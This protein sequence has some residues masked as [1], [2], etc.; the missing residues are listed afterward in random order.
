MVSGNG[1]P[2]AHLRCAGFQTRRRILSA[3]GKTES[4]C[5]WT[6]GVLQS[7]HCLNEEI[8]PAVIAAVI[9]WICRDEPV[10]PGELA[11]DAGAVLVFL[12][13]TQDIRDVETALLSPPFA[14]DLR[15][16]ILVLPLHGQLSTED[17]SRVFEI[18]PPGLR[19]IVLATN[20]AESSVTIPDVVYVI[21]SG[22]LKERRFD[23]R[24]KV[25]SLQTHWAS[26]ANNKQRRGRAGRVR[27]GMCVHLFLK[28]RARILKPF[29]TPEMRRVPLEELCLT[30]KLLNLGRVAPVLAEALEPP[31]AA[32]IRIALDALHGIG[33]LDRSERLTALGRSLAQLPLEPRAGKMLVLAAALGVLGPALTIAACATTRDPFFRPLDKRDQVDAIKIQLGGRDSYSDAMVLANT[34]SQWVNSGRSRQWCDDH[35]VSMNTMSTIAKARDQLLDTLQKCGIG[36]RAAN[37]SVD[38]GESRRLVMLR[39]AITGAMWPN[40]ALVAGTEPTM[41]KDG[42]RGQR[43]LLH[44]RDNCG[45]HAHPVSVSPVH[46]RVYA[47]SKRN[48]P[49]VCC[50]TQP[51]GSSVASLSPPSCLSIA[52]YNTKMMTSDLYVDGVTLISSVTAVSPCRLVPYFLP[53]SGGPTASPSARS[54]N[55]IK[56]GRNHSVRWGSPAQVLFGVGAKI[57]SPPIHSYSGVTDAGFVQDGWIAATAPEPVARCLQKLRA[58][59]DA[60]VAEH[61]GAGGRADGPYGSRVPQDPPEEARKFVDEIGK[62]LEFEQGL[63]GARRFPAS[64]GSYAYTPRSAQPP[65][66]L[67]DNQPT[68]RSGFGSTQPERASS[69]RFPVSG[70]GTDSGPARLATGYARGRQMQ[71]DRDRGGRAR[72]WS[73]SRSPDDNRRDIR[74][75][76]WSRSRSRSPK[77]MHR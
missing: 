36:G 77:R 51:Q 44:S 37:F 49:K 30:I 9:S 60:L 48:S 46:T 67:Y 14:Q 34:F 71:F 43:L 70:S 74:D 62:L 18:P 33:A 47:V 4:G 13:G 21:N 39:A 61:V 73:R 75:R 38:Q 52:M 19:K 64:T 40:V 56:P 55:T 57:Y 25:S 1:G 26:A 66:S 11:G 7:G 20:V 42:R 65:R 8:S 5:C 23:A 27:P 35:F 10:G 63:G 15:Q 45:L 68:A 76:G 69:A 6:L 3:G 16:R 72:S 58:G 17:Q 12:P 32:S 41:S 50:R 59:I 54:S 53:L 31:E 24:S 29:Q 22:K 28:E 2:V